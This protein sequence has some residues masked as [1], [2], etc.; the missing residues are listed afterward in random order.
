MRKSFDGL[1]SIVT[2]EFAM[3]VMNGYYL[4]L[5]TSIGPLQDIDVGPRWSGGVGQAF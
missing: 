4:V 1:H 5:I 2:N 3:D